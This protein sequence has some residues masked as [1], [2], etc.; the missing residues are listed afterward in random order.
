MPATECSGLLNNAALTLRLALF[1][2]QRG[3]ALVCP[4][5]NA[6][7]I[8][9]AEVR[10]E[11]RLNTCAI[12]LSAFESG[13]FF[14]GDTARFELRHIDAGIAEAIVEIPYGRREATA[15]S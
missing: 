15:Q 5:A 1:E 13:W 12:E 9:R 8:E 10:I 7:F 4:R 11:P 3:S 14:Y 2:G 6:M